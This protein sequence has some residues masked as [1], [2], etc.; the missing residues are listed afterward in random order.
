MYYQNV[1]GLNSCIADYLLASSCSCYDVVA[2]TET[3]LNDRTI[4]S[5]IFGPDYVVFRCDRSPRNSKKNTGGGVLIAVKSNFHALLIDDDSW[6][7]LELVWTRIDLGNRKLYV[8]VL[9]LPPDR[10]R[11]VALAESLSRC[12]SKVSSLCAPEDDIL[13]IGDFNM[14]G[15][16][17]CSN[18]GSFLYPDPVRSTFSAPSNIILDSLSTA[19]LRQINR[20][21]NENGR[22]LDLCFASDGSRVPTIES[23]PAPFV[24]A[25]QHHPA[26]MVSLEVTGLHASVEKSA[27]FYLDFKKADFDAISHILVTIDW[28]S[29]L[30]LLNPN[31]A[32]E[33]FSHI[34]NYVIDRHVPKRTTSGNSRTPWFTKELRRLKT[35]KRCALRNYH[36]LKF[37]QTKDVYRR[38][39][40]AYKKASK[41]CYQNYLFRVQRN[42]K[43]NPKS[44][45]KHVKS[46]R[47]EPG[48][49]TQMFLDGNTANSEGGICALFA[50]KFSSTF[51]TAS[52]SREHVEKAVRNVS[53]LGFSMST[54]VVEDAVI[55]KAAAKLKN[56]L[57]TGPDDSSSKLV[58]TAPPTLHCGRKPTCFQSIKR[59]TEEIS[60]TIEEFLLYVQS[61][62]YSN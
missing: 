8:C 53:P 26:L 1:G 37:S 27:P 45:W 42:L 52:T 57:S 15:L 19:T 56:S 43:A 38:L 6:H 54:I 44:F 39:N 33:T 16:K 3:W 32:A 9:Y 23:A 2:F 48:I 28:E 18:H 21:T 61:P 62:N 11:D 41:R 55:S 4:S 40:S 59:G 22:M 36:K 12:I 5:Q 35:A 50:Q 47:N 46:Q 49:P 17:W 29:E 14:P 31:A 25:V 24:K 60:T 58:L 20:V 51:A 30:N 10:T 7:D 13:V 34:L